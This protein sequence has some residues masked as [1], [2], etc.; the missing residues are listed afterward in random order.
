M[1]REPR[2][3]VDPAGI[4]PEVL[5]E[6]LGITVLWVSIEII[7]EDR[8]FTGVI[9]RLHPEGANGSPRRSLPS[10]LWPNA[11]LLHH[12]VSAR[13]HRLM[14]PAIAIAMPARK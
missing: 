5:T 6:A 4:T 13:P 3:P 1:V 14:L 7:D 11:L 2:I 8:G 10:S 9:A 12:G